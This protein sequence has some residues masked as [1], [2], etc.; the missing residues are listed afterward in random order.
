MRGPGHLYTRAEFHGRCAGITP[1][2][3]SVRRCFLSTE[4]ILLNVNDLP[5]VM[6]QVRNKQEARHKRVGCGIESL[7]LVH[8][9]AAFLEATRYGPFY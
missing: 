3:T 1:D 9:S 5:S 4:C 6:S 7:P 8:V 2:R